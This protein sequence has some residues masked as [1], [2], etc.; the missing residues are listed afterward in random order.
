MQTT[1][2][3]V[4]AENNRRS[5]LAAARTALADPDA[6]V[7]MAEISRQAGVGMATLYRNFPG[8]RELLEALYSDEV[9]AICRAAA[10]VE[11]TSDGARLIAWLREFFAFVA[12]KRQVASELLEYTDRADPIFGGSRARVN[13]AGLPLLLAAQR[14]AQIRDDLSLDQ[15]LDTVHAVATI[16]GDRDYLRPILDSVLEGLRLPDDRAPE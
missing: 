10:G 15:V 5:I 12:S 7:S 3:R 16:R 2:R 8:K 13:A 11:G 14:A 9:D 6:D 1:A 4:D